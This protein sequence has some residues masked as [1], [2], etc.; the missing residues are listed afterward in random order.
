VTLSKI[1]KEGQ[2]EE[3]MSHLQQ[4]V[5]NL[6]GN[7]LLTVGMFQR[8][9]PILWRVEAFIGEGPAST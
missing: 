2:M 1:I 6:T 8:E 3:Q 4:E 7:W 9:S 5:E